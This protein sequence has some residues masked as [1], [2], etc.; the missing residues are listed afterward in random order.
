MPSR[1]VYFEVK[2]AVP[3]GETRCS[4]LILAGAPAACNKSARE[5]KR[6]ATF[7]LA[8]R[9]CLSLR[10]I[11]LPYEESINQKKITNSLFFL[12]YLSSF[13]F[14]V[15]SALGFFGAPP[16]SGSQLL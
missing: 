15:L 13:E 1:Q 6:L 14:F 8:S 2:G 5:G 10:R 11:T 3:P 12:F 4:R 7:P 9:G 16:R